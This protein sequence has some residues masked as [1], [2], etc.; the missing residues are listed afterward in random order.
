[1]QKTER[2]FHF[3]LKASHH[4]CR[5][6]D[7]V[8]LKNGFDYIASLPAS[9]QIESEKPSLGATYNCLLLSRYQILFKFQ[10]SLF[11]TNVELIFDDVELILAVE[12]REVTETERERVWKRQFELLTY[13]RQH[14]LWAVSTEMGRK[15]AH[16]IHSIKFNCRR[17][18][19][20]ELIR[21]LSWNW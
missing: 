4:L 16:Q 3:F 8:T 17:R 7:A 11:L 18:V 10:S 12:K 21:C 5:F 20:D 1:M 9:C 6:D 13:H 14:H 2:M 19:Y 15:L